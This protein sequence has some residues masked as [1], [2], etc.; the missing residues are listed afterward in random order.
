MLFDIARFVSQISRQRP[1][2]SDIGHG[3]CA[4]ETDDANS[5]GVAVTG[6]INIK[7]LL[8][9]LAGQQMDKIGVICSHEKRE[10]MKNADKKR[11]R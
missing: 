10:R 3:S 5:G 2:R 11:H 1:S 6:A 7:L 8:D 9:L 4:Q